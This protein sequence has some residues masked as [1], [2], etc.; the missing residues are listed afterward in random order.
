MYHSHKAKGYN[1]KHKLLNALSNFTQSV[2]CV[3]F[4]QKKFGRI[5]DVSQDIKI[6]GACR[7]MFYILIVRYVSELLQAK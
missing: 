5:D 1:S 2:V 7:Q 4:L 3:K 6:K